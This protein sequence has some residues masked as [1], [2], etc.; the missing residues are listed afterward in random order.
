MG[1][2]VTRWWILGNY[3]GDLAITP[4][5]KFVFS[6]TVYRNGVCPMALTNP[7]FI[8]SSRLQKASENDPP[9]RYGERGHA[10]RLVQQTLIDQGFP[11]PISVRMYGSPDGIFGNET[12]E[13]VRA[14]QR[15]WSLQVDGIVGRQTL[16]TMDRTLPAAPPLVPALPQPATYVVPGLKVAIAQ[17]SPQT[18]WATA[19]TMMRSWKDRQSY[20]IGPLINKLG[21][22]YSTYFANDQV[23]PYSQTDAFMRAAG[24]HSAPLQSF[25]VE[26]WVE[27]LRAHGLLFVGTL[28]MPGTGAGHVRVLYGVGGRGAP[29]TTTMMVLDPDGGRDYQETLERWSETYRGDAINSIDDANRSGGNVNAQV[30][31]FW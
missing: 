5:A 28:N 23:L 26:A 27:M 13:Q 2:F 31:Y 16:T 12:R 11:L 6:E 14:Y 10:V 3:T 29:D 1:E 30:G 21:P 20:Q 4:L 15:S 18:C 7:R 9:M 8:P 19:Y 24:L 25:S 22:P 17:P